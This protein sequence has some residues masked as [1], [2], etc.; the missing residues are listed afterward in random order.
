MAEVLA[1]EDQVLV[2]RWTHVVA[3]TTSVLRGVIGGTL[4]KSHRVLTEFLSERLGL[5]SDAITTTV[6]AAAVEGAIQ[7]SQTRW[8]F[9][10]GDLALAVSDGLEVL[11]HGVGADLT[12]WAGEA[13]AAGVAR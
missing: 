9:Q 4:L 2:R 7:A 6:L 5:P 3:N 11:E 1:A 10:G 13:G 8:F 12:A